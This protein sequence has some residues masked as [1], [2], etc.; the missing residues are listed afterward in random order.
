MVRVSLHIVLVIKHRVNT[1]DELVKIPFDFGVEIDIR[2]S[3]AEII[4]QHEP[5]ENGVKFKE[6]LKYFNHKFLI[7]NVKEDGL[8]PFIYGLLESSNHYN[9]F[10]LDQS[11]PSLYRFSRDFPEFCAVRVSDIESIETA[12]QLRAGWIWFDSHSGNWDYLSTIDNSIF[13]I[14]P[15]KCLVSPELQRVNFE[16]ELVGLKNS[17]NSMSFKFEAVCTKLPSRWV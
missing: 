17:I 10:F 6:W 15:K 3:G 4:V 8:E 13:D 12:I 9:F 5:F 2:T 7:I 16:S 1:I 14:P 11:F